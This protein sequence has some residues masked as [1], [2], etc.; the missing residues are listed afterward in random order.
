MKQ[1]EE[2]IEVI[3]EKISWYAG[4]KWERLDGYS[5]QFYL[6]HARIFLSELGKFN[7][8]L[9]DEDQTIPP[10]P[11]QAEAPAK[12]QY[13]MGKAMLEAKFKK[14]IPLSQVLKEVK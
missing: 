11:P 5:R 2:L 9:I 14:V 3:A 10:C 8:A 12:C 7:L 6:D 1:V 13:Y 4:Y